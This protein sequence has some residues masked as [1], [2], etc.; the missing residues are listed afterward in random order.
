MTAPL[1][2]RSA[3]VTGAS[4]GLGRAFARALDAQGVRLTVTG[5][6]AE[7]LD[8]LRDELRG[9]T[10]VVPADIREPGEVERLVAEAERRWDG[11]DIL[12]S[13]AG[14]YA[15]GEFAASSQD[16]IRELVDINVYA[17]IA[18]VRAALPAMIERGGG[19]VVLT[20]SIAGSHDLDWEPVYAATKHAVQSFAHTLRHQLAGTGVRV[21]AISPGVVLNE[22]WGY[23]EGDPGTAARVAE[24]VADGTG[25]RSEDV[26]D[27]VTWMLTR[28]RHVTIRDVTILP[29]AQR[30]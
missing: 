15:H 5:R 14:V 11:L 20:S 13:N 7:R 3:L 26:A 24:R 9:R 28:P 27:A 22:L 30:I 12:L 21:G 29:S 16:E 10:H 8:A 18:L 4:S 6:S 2:G 1:E 17:A 23:P 19:D 25:I